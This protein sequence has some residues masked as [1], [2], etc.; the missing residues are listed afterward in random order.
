[1]TRRPTMHAQP[2]RILKRLVKQYGHELVEDPRR[3]EAL[4]RDLCGRH[5][6]E[7]FVLVNAQ[8]QRVPSELLNAPKWLPSAAT[9]T[10][11]SR[12]LQSK[13][14]I[15]PEAA[16]WAV[17]TWANALDLDSPAPQRERFN[18]L[19]P[20]LRP[21]LPDSHHHDAPAKGQN[22]ESRV[23]SGEIENRAARRRRTRA[24]RAEMTSRQARFRWSRLMPPLA[25]IA[26]RIAP[27][28]AQ[29]QRPGYL[30]SSLIGGA[31]V[32]ASTGLLL[33]VLA[34]TRL[35]SSPLAAQTETP[36]PGL[37]AT[38]Q[39]VVATA[40]P[41]APL[42][43]DARA[44]TLTPADYLRRAFAPPALARVSAN[45]GLLVRDGPS[46]SFP[47]VGHLA[48]GEVVNI[49]GYSEDGAWSNIDRPQSGWVSNDF[50][51]LESRESIGVRVQLRV[52]MLE[53]KPYQAALR[54]APRPDA[55]V[56]ATLP[57]NTPIVAVASTVG[58]AVGWLQVIEPSTGW[59][60]LNDVP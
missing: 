3:T 55:T 46:T 6:R 19:P 59:L 53:T 50:L 28:V 39:P 10:R 48:L 18:W 43:N 44:A 8:R 12:L 11:L 1:M 13:L 9:H 14:A 42:L 23:Q 49:V 47:R 40:V 17:E 26:A 52:R 32:L 30:R 60:S 24:Q 38:V 34:L 56:I 7:I 51:H 57:P 58:N 5:T 4:L 27:F 36:A 22:A 29:A 31:L 35:P 25:R 33:L 20:A 54:A 2:Q 37:E 45:D 41:A 15:T 21:M 16:D